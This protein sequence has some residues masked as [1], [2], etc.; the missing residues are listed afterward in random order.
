MCYETDD[1]FSSRHH[2]PLHL[3]AVLTTRNALGGLHFWKDWSCE[4]F[5]PMSPDGIL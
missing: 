2:F 1:E 5:P 3:S 4:F